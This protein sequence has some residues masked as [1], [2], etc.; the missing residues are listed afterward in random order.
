LPRPDR[1]DAISDDPRWP[2]SHGLLVVYS[3]VFE[4]SHWP[5]LGGI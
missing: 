3:A 2:N 4:F 5:S 1:P